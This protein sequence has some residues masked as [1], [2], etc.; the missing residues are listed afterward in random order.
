MRNT[1]KVHKPHK[2]MFTHDYH[3]ALDARAISRREF[4]PVSRL[5]LLCV[6]VDIKYGS[7]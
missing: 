5:N 6:L 1:N 7:S 3:N 4:D 2:P